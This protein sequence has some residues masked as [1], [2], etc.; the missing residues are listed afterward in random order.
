M[1]S[2]YTTCPLFTRSK[3]FGAKKKAY[4]IAIIDDYSRRIMHAEFFFEERYPRLERCVQK[5][6]LKYGVPI[7]FSVIMALSIAQNS[8]K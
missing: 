7:C 2:R 5:A 3:S 1:A 6:V 4:L 8:L